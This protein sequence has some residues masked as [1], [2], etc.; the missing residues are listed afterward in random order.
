MK[1]ILEIILASLVPLSIAAT[2]LAQLPHHA[3]ARRYP[4][5]PPAGIRRAA[6]R[7]RLAHRSKASRLAF[8]HISPLAVVSLLEFVR[9]AHARQLARHPRVM[10]CR[11]KPQR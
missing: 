1:D 10:R 3:P 2:P 9:Y 8:R 5:P 4:A 11:P 6:L 7:R